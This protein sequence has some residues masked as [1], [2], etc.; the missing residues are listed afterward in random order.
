[1]IQERTGLLP[2]AYFSGTKIAWMLDHVDGARARAEKGKLGLK[3]TDLDLEVTDSISD[4]ID[5][6]NTKKIRK[7]AMKTLGDAR[8]I[9][10][11]KPVLPETDRVLIGLR[12][13]TEKRF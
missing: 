3:A 8:A 4:G 11:V 10:R 13:V 1:M 2:D 12:S 5:S 6:I 7:T 9:V